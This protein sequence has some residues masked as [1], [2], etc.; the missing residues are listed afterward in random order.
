ME[1]TNSIWNSIVYFG[2]WHKQ[3]LICFDEQIDATN[4]RY[5]KPVNFLS[6]MNFIEQ[7]LK[8]HKFLSHL[9]HRHSVSGDNVYN[10]N[11]LLKKKKLIWPVNYLLISFISFF[12]FIIFLYFQALYNVF[13]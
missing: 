11:N 5:E 6:F 3:K 10:V 1:V 2:K 12:L 13:N 8:F 9:L 7:F 4:P